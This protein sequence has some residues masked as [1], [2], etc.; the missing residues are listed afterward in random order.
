MLYRLDRLCEAFSLDRE[1]ARGWV[2]V[3]TNA[4]GG[5]TEHREVVEWLR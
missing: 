4:W 5:G 2:L 1:R 3:Q